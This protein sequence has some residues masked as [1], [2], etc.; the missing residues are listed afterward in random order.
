MSK[1]TILIV[2]DERFFCTLLQHILEDSYQIVCVSSAQEGMAALNHH[3]IDLILLDIMM[4]DMDG[5]QLCQ[6]I[7]N[8][9]LFCKIPIIFLTVKSEMADEIRGFELGAVDYITKPVS[10]PHRTNQSS[11]TPGISKGQ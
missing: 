10:P 5:Y 11:N 2:D 4:P 9:E 3:T 8:T 1:D 7:K 6:Q